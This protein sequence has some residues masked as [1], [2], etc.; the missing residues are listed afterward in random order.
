MDLEQR[1]LTS[2]VYV[3]DV[4]GGKLWIYDSKTDSVESFKFTTVEDLI[5]RLEPGSI[6]IGEKASFNTPRKPLSRSQPLTEQELFTFQALCKEKDII[7]KIWPEKMTPSILAYTGL[8]KSDENDPKAIYLWLKDHPERFAGLQNPSASFEPSPEYKVGWALRKLCN[9][10]LNYCR[11]GVDSPYTDDLIS[12]LVRE[13]IDALLDRLPESTVRLLNMPE[14]ER[15]TEKITSYELEEDYLDALR[16]QFAKKKPSETYLKIVTFLES[17]GKTDRKVVKDELG[18]RSYSQLDTLTKKGILNKIVDINVLPWQDAQIHFR[19]L[20]TL[21][22]PMLCPESGKVTQNELTESVPTWNF[23]KKHVFVF[24]PNHHKGGVASSNIWHWVF[25]PWVKR[26][27]KEAGFDFTRKVP[28][29]DKPD[30]LKTV[31]P[32]EFTKEESDFFRAKKRKEFRDHCRII[33]NVYRDMIYGKLRTKELQYEEVDSI[34]M[35][36]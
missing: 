18:L 26:E 32:G 5:D 7:F 14:T 4:G 20:C 25:P 6:F 2:R 35:Y 15:K 13:N 33:Y 23:S 31:Q 11:G 30:E 10:R 27:G 9:A 21:L 29:H 19:L 36:Q 16:S 3:G 34:L 8:S 1:F 17:N 22:A 12:T 28:K 24:G